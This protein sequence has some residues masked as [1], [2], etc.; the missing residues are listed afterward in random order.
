MPPSFMI[1][2]LAFAATQRDAFSDLYDAAEEAASQGDG[3]QGGGEQQQGEQQQGQPPQLPPVLPVLR[4]GEDSDE[5]AKRFPVGIDCTIPLGLKYDPWKEVEVDGVYQL[6]GW[7]PLG[8]PFTAP[9]A[10][11]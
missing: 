4:A 11:I 1:A 10:L 3:S 6:G 9:P 2:L 5:Y 8:A 7:I